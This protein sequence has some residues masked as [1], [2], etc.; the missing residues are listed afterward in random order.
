MG[1][2]ESPSTTVRAGVLVATIVQIG[3]HTSNPNSRTGTATAMDRAM[4]TATGTTSHRRCG[5]HHHRAIQDLARAC[6]HHRRRPIMLAAG[7][8]IA[9]TVRTATPLRR[10]R[11]VSTEATGDI[12]E[13]TKEATRATHH[14]RLHHRKD[15]VTMIT[16]IGLMAA[17]EVIVTV[18]VIEAVEVAGVAIDWQG[19]TSRVSVGCLG[20]F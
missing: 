20:T 17:I 1:A 14:D 9:V 12:R 8:I 3:E 16:T 13:A 15:M 19:Y 4:D 2:E 11:P 7:M 10:R 18:E 5:S 6:R